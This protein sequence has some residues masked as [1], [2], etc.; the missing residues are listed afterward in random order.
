MSLIFEI[1]LSLFS[2]DCD[3]AD[4]RLT[5]SDLTQNSNPAVERIVNIVEKNQR[6]MVLQE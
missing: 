3:L 4:W 2:F 5:F 6:L 1:Y